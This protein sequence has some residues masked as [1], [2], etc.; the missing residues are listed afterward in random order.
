M[1]TV[2]CVAVNAGCCDTC[3]MN[4]TLPSQRFAV[5]LRKHRVAHGLSQEKLAERAGLHRNFI[6]GG[7]GSLSFQQKP[8]LLTPQGLLENSANPF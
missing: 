7:A 1:R 4:A 3:C 5:L 8:C 2:Y 6:G